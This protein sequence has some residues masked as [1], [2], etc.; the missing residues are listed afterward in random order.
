M[1][2]LAEHARKLNDK[3]AGVSEAEARS[4]NLAALAARG[5]DVA[6]FANTEIPLQHLSALAQDGELTTAFVPE[7][8][9]CE[10][11]R[12]LRMIDACRSKHELNKLKRLCR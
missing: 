2:A 6:A 4:R 10:S 12:A 3:Y 5:V 11:V 9:G 1:D 8:K 7:P